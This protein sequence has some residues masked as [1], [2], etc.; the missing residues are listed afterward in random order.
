MSTKFLRVRDIATSYS[1]SIIV[2]VETDNI[3]H[4]WDLN[5]S[6]KLCQFESV[7]ETGGQRLAV[8]ENGKICA[9][10][11]YHRNGIAMYD[12]HTGN[13]IW[14]RRDLKKVQRLK[15]SRYYQNNLLANFDRISCHVLDKDTGETKAL[16]KAVRGVTESPFERVHLLIKA[17]VADIIDFDNQQLIGRIRPTSFAILDSIFTT[18][19]IVLSEAGGATYCY[20]T[21]DAKLIWR[22]VPEKGSHILSL[23]Y[24]QETK[25][26]LGMLWSYEKGGDHH[27]VALNKNSGEISRKC[28]I[29]GTLASTS[30]CLKGTRLITS[31]GDVFNTSDGQ[32]TST[33]DFL[34][35][36]LVKI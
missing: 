33:L 10:G 5:S 9:A 3:V 29:P 36:G 18:D 8:S 32:V 25:E 1:G 16:L 22:Y 31:I 26:V 34:S 27:L 28:L 35:F 7:F 14:E 2:T 13:M 17:R 11:A 23:A 20:S 4:V 30:F 19:S 6:S 12:T 15:F 21:K 24:C